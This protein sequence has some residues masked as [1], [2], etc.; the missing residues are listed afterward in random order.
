MLEGIGFDTG[1]SNACC[2][3]LLA[4]HEQI[5]VV[6][7]RLS[8]H[9]D[10]RLTI[11]VDC[12]KSISPCPV[13]DS[14]FTGRSTVVLACLTGASDLGSASAGTIPNWGASVNGWP[15]LSTLWLYGLNLSGTIPYWGPTG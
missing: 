4:E 15:S 5:L 7:G 3:M 13:K 9:H 2:Q 8:Q 10:G 12:F 14:A 6:F 1:P 11:R